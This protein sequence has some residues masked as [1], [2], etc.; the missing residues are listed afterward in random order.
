MKTKKQILSVLFGVGI[1]LF[2]GMFLKTEQCSAVLN[3]EEREYL[4]NLVTRIETYAAEIQRRDLDESEADVHFQQKLFTTEEVAEVARL[5]AQEFRG[6][7]L[8]QEIVVP[9]GGLHVVGDVH[10]YIVSSV[11][12]A[13]AAEKSGAAVLQL[14]DLRDRGQNTIATMMYWYIKRLLRPDRFYMIIGNHDL[15]VV[16]SNFNR[17]TLINIFG[18]PYNDKINFGKNFEPY[19]VPFRQDFTRCQSLLDDLQGYV[20]V[21]ASITNQARSGRMLA[22]HG[23]VGP[24][25]KASLGALSRI[26]TPFDYKREHNGEANWTHDDEEGTFSGVVEEIT[27]SD[28]SCSECPPND[29]TQLKKR[30]WSPGRR[31]QGVIFGKEFFFDFCHSHGFF[32]VITGH[33][34]SPNSPGLTQY[35][36]EDGNDPGKPKIYTTLGAPGIVRKDL[37]RNKASFTLVDDSLNI[38]GTDYDS[39]EANHRWPNFLPILFKQVKESVTRAPIAAPAAADP[40]LNKVKVRIQLPT[41]GAL[42]WKIVHV[43][44]EHNTEE[45]IEAIKKLTNTD[46][47]RYGSK[48]RITSEMVGRDEVFVAELRYKVRLLMPDSLPKLKMICSKKVLTKEELIQEIRGLP[49]LDFTDKDLLIRS[50]L[51]IEGEEIQV[52][53]TKNPVAQEEPPLPPDPNERRQPAPARVR[54]PPVLKKRIPRMA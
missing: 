7:P 8:M 48:Y 13:N 45:V 21:A 46:G 1:I 36:T 39:E 12:Q 5:T 29:E 44:D 32:A 52:S 38:Q 14:G 20:P 43:H 18:K 54:K 37:Q 17:G 41:D 30:G 10:G 26:H 28:P 22:V 6:I 27:W 4:T 51:N 19:L 16:N 40:Q 42:K 34:H 11:R 24:K 25:A 49:N 9:D 23:G 33:R 31:K 50:E 15:G 47:S 35:F 2:S 53:V 3:H